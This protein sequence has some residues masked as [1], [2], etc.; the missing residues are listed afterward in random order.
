MNY[1]VGWC[2][3]TQDFNITNEHVLN[4]EYIYIYI[5]YNCIIIYF[6]QL[7]SILTILNAFYISVMRTAHR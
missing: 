7:F 4:R 3:V 1:A 6:T 5:F 2:Q